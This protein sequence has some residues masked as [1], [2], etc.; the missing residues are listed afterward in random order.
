MI[1]DHISEAI[2]LPALVRLRPNLYLAR[3]E[4]MK[5]YS[6]LIAVEAL[7]QSGRIDRSTTLLD[8]SSGI[9]AYALALAC[10]RYGL[11]CHTCGIPNLRPHITSTTSDTRCDST[12]SKNRG[13]FEARSKAPDR[14]CK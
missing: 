12:T 1:Y 9:Y 6:T 8:S 2:K 14:N 5:V 4:T 7:L 10:H 13:V 11:K 3:F